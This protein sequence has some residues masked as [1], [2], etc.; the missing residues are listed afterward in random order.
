M[1]YISAIE[2]RHRLLFAKMMQ[3]KAIGS[4]KPKSPKGQDEKDASETQQ[5]PCLEENLPHS[6][7]PNH[8]IMISRQTPGMRGEKGKGFHG[9]RHYVGRNHHSSQGGKNDGQKYGP[10][11]YLCLCFTQ[12]GDQQSQAICGQSQGEGNDHQSRKISRPDVKG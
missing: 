4:M 5:D 9:S 1:D 6:Q 2:K 12:G 7:P 8:H 10:P 11:A 3:P